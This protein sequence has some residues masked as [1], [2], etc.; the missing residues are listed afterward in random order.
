MKNKA[1]LVLMEQA[2][3]LLIFAL[4]AALCLQAFAWS[5]RR[6]RQSADT[7]AALRYAQTTAELVRHHRGDLDSAALQGGGTVEQGR[8]VCTYGSLTATALLQAS[9]TPLLGQALVTVTAP[10][11]RVLA[12]LPVG[13]Q[14][15]AP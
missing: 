10:D 3:M 12:Q 15:V 5:D 2:L 9:P 8:W 6:A 1:S 14:E 4:A 11:G 13:W 7:D